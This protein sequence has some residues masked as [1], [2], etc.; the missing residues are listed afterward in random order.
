LISGIS[1]ANYGGTLSIT[2]VTSDNTALLPGDTF[3]LFTAGAHTGDFG[4]VSGSP[5]PTLAYTFNPA[6][7]VL[8]VVTTASNP[9]NM[10]I[11]LSGNMVTLSWPA[12]HLH[13]IAQSNSVSPADPAAWVDIPGSQSVTSLNIT[14]SPTQPQM[15][16]RLLHP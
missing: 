13:W 3:T 9:T 11:S 5:G 4:I 10:T 12:D 2:N 16:F 15:F 1:T 14:L 8:T 6:T 7:G